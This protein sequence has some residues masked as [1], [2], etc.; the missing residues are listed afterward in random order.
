MVDLPDVQEAAARATG[1]GC[2]RAR[3]AVQ[4]ADGLAGS[5]QETRLRLLLGRSS[6]PPAVAQYSVR[7][8]GIFVARV[9]FAWPE[10]R[11]VL[12]VTAQ[13]VRDPEAL[14]RRI[15]AGLAR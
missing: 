15:A 9:D 10:N 8:R 11:R 3:A 5:P 14:R 6:L 4:L 2:R 13:D 12:F 1:H 7:D